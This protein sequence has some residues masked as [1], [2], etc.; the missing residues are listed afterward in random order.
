M[1]FPQ[2]NEIQSPQKSG[3]LKDRENNL[4]RNEHSIKECGALHITEYNKL[5]V[6]PAS[7]RLATK[8][9]L[10][11]IIY[12]VAKVVDSTTLVATSIQKQRPHPSRSNTARRN[13]LF[14]FQMN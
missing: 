10:I 5:T 13:S 14:R 3:T 12:V 9:N 4:A 1:Q 7:G 8:S 6:A 2:Q 11:S